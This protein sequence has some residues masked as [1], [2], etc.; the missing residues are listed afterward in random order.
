MFHDS[1]IALYSSV[2]LCVKVQYKIKR[3]GNCSHQPDYSIFYV[4][5]YSIPKNVS[6][7]YGAYYQHNLTNVKNNL[8]A[9]PVQFSKEQVR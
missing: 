7:L 8:A 4:C 2:T 3:G 6:D 5:A 9:M 1:K